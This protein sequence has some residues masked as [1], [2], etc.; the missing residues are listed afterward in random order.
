MLVEPPGVS[1]QT[2]VPVEG[3]T[4]V[5]FNVVVILAPAGNNH[6]LREQT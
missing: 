5:V 3:M 4:M 2:L 1:M 6:T